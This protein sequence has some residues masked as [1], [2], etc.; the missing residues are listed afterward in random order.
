MMCWQYG[1]ESRWPPREVCDFV[2]AAIEATAPWYE[3]QKSA[4]QVRAKR[5]EYEWWDFFRIP[6]A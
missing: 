1:S 4:V 5:A 6:Q 3:E 2:A